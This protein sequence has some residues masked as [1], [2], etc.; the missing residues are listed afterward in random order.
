MLS[1]V[2]ET[3]RKRITQPWFP[4][5]TPNPPAVMS[6]IVKMCLDVSPGRFWII[7]AEIKSNALLC[8]EVQAENW[9]LPCPC[10][11]VSI[12]AAHVVSFAHPKSELPDLEYFFQCNELKVALLSLLC[13]LAWG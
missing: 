10:C 12:S 5:K 9:S 11:V 6:L 2:T 3:L 7:L 4:S 1:S 8:R 13:A